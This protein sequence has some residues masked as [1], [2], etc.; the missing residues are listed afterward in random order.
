MQRVEIW[1]R[2]GKYFSI[3]ICKCKLY[4]ALC[5]CLNSVAHDHI[6][7]MSHL[8]RT[9]EHPARADKSALGAIN[10]PLRVVG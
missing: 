1:L 9:S 10:R 8:M 5:K 4:P 7:G 6:V 2:R 3:S